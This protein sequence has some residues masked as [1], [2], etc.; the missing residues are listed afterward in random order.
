MSALRPVFGDQLSPGLPSL[1]D[2]DKEKDILLLAEVMDEASYVN[3]HKQ[4][5]IFT[6]SSMRHFAEEMRDKGYNV[7]YVKL[8]DKDNTGSLRGEIARCA[9]EVKPEKI[10]LT[11]SGE[12]RLNS[13]LKHIGKD[14]GIDTEI[15]EDSRFLCSRKDF[16]G[17]AKNR[18]RLTMEYFYREN[19]KRAGILMRGENDP[20]GGQWNYDKD[21]RKSPPKGYSPGHRRGFR[22]DDVTK[23]VIA[24]VKKHFPGNIGAA[25]PFTWAVTR[26][27][28]EI[29]RRHFM[30]DHLSAFGDYQDAMVTD[31][32][33]MHHSLISPY[34]NN[35]LLDPLET[36]RMAEKAYYDGA[37]PLNAVEG[38]IRQILGWRE[39]VRGIYFYFMPEYRERNAL[40]ADKPLPSCYWT[41]DTKMNCMRAAIGSTVKHGYSHHI[42]RLMITGNFALLAGINP[43]EVHEWYLG[44]YLDA[45]EWVELPNT[46]GMALYA[47]GGIVG[48]KPYIAGGAYINRMSDFCKGCA[49]K[50]DKRSGDN[51]CPFTV[52]YWHFLFR[53]TAR[54]KDN[55]RMALMLR[56]AGNIADDEKKA[57]QEKA[58]EYD[59]NMERL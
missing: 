57:I 7:R 50:H 36:C 34:I 55:R 5:L 47:D 9:K 6:F 38:F 43:H 51:A 25:E 59:E 3:H 20:E 11:E 33:F 54:F 30:E 15:C 1:K 32:P 48:T 28:A 10:L 52:F 29:A 44:V 56:N 40:N 35:G 16:S 42:Q 17:W 23:E 19:R 41:G 46:L 37:A 13:E 39:F 26:E 27:E 12:Y 2:A 24:S 8:T 21:N 53:H 22:P 45:Y 18:K 31:E 49:Y 58:A 14:T 4:K